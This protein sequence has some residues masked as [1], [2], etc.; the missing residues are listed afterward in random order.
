MF[1]SSITLGVRP[2]EYFLSRLNTQRAKLK[3][4]EYRRLPD[5]L[6][7]TPGRTGSTWL[8]VNLSK[9]PRIYVPVEKELK[10]FSSMWTKL[11]L[12]WYLNQF[13]DSP[14]VI[15]GET[16]PS[17]ATLPTY[18]IRF[19]HEMMPDL[20]LIFVLREPVSRAWSEAKHYFQHHSPDS[21]APERQD[22]APILEYMFS[23]G[24][25]LSG[26]YEDQLGRY[27]SCFP[28]EQIFVCFFDEILSQPDSLLN[29]I[30][31]FL[32]VE[33]I[34]D[35]SSFPLYE[36]MNPSVSLPAPQEIKKY[37]C[38]L[39]APRVRR[40]DSFLKNT[41]GLSVPEG[42]I[43]A[44]DEASIDPPVCLC[45]SEGCFSIYIYDGEFLA[46]PKETDVDDM[47]RDAVGEAIRKGVFY[48]G[49]TL[50]EAATQ[51]NSHFDLEERLLA[52]LQNGDPVATFTWLVGSY[53]HGYN[54]VLWGN[55]FYGLSLEL[56]VIDLPYVARDQMKQF[57]QAGSIV[58]GKTLPEVMRKIVDV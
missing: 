42:W 20:K 19:L 58:V 7:C 48:R 54:I 34:N 14:D 13:P 15:K 21:I 50:T 55:R 32:G 17:Y 41:W 43:E 33:E 25:I 36:K 28:Q 49:R 52:G 56:G 51:V 12:S 27:M 38:S 46:V 40:L 37:V 4:A 10:F 16:T 5:F 39:Y 8:H 22:F 45:S 24:P 31:R 6:I 11:T 44:A 26:D 18:R 53:F 3:D 23:D 1:T 35:Y 47:R 9:H 30:F 2:G 29:R 57:I